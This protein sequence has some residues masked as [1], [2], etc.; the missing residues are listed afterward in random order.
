MPDFR[1]RWG[2][3]DEGGWGVFVAYE[4]GPAAGWWRLVAEFQI[5]IRASDYADYEN[6]L[7]YLDDADP[8]RREDDAPP[9]ELPEVP[10]SGITPPRLV[11]RMD[12]VSPR[13]RWPLDLT[14]QRF[15]ALTALSLSDRV[16]KNRRRYWR[17]RCDCGNEVEVRSDH[18][19]SGATQSCGCER[20]V[21]SSERVAEAKRDE[22]GHFV[23]ESQ[24]SAESAA[25]PP[26]PEADH[27]VGSDSRQGEIAAIEQ[28]AKERG[29]TKLP[30][31]GDPSLKNIADLKWDKTKQKW[32]RGETAAKGTA[33]V[34]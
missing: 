12:G 31:S 16:A 26:A 32:T 11:D 29:I 1:Y 25:P 7:L 20:Q 4:S 19:T 24:E 18:L 10:P 8:F 30:P 3:L 33:D 14:G 17:C 22:A 23:G 27:T 13:G 34:R 21:S 28:F 5:E 9:E 15:G 2:K 6:R